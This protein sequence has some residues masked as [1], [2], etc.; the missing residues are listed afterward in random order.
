[1]E[2]NDLR[3]LVYSILI[4]IAFVAVAFL[5]MGALILLYPIILFYLFHR[6]KIW[7]TKKRAK[8]G[9]IA[10][11]IASLFAL[12]YYPIGDSNMHQYYNS[13]EISG[14]NQ[15]ILKNVTFNFYPT[16]IYYI[17]LT[18]TQHV[19]AFL[20]LN[21]VNESNGNL[22]PVRNYSSNS[23]FRA[24]LY[25]TKFSIDVSNLSSGIYVTNVSLNNGSLYV[26]IY[27]PRM[28]SPQE[29][30]SVVD[31]MALFDTLYMFTYIFLMSELLFLA[32]I[33]GA[34]TMRKGRQVVSRQQ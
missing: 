17:N 11:V 30:N 29:F 12:I 10:I 1:M 13:Y 21:L 4:G 19:S 14:N 25:Y 7:Q 34:H 31:K 18:T 32:I 6:M 33:F 20:T 26:Y 27:A 5:V 24:G 9:T 8:I 28:L 2:S 22:I 3:I 16:N 23:T 15:T